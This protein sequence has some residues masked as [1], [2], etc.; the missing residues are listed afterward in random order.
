MPI[1]QLPTCK[2]CKGFKLESKMAMNLL[3]RIHGFIQGLFKLNCFF[4][5]T[6]QSN[7]QLIWKFLSL[8]LYHWPIKPAC[9]VD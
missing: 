4:K 3:I 7:S 5:S 6:L 8:L 2:G 1:A 9:Q